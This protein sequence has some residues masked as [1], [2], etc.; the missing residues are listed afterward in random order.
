MKLDIEDRVALVVGAS[1]GIGFAIADA[2]AAEGA[3][4]AVAARGLDDLKSA[5]DQ[6]GRGASCHPADVTDP[7]AARRWWTKSKNN[8][9]GST[10]SSATSAAAHQCR[11]ATKPRRNGR[12]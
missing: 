10:S 3:K 2:L 8:G 12:G 11:R 9:A 5:A 4:V 7:A 1:R 6:I